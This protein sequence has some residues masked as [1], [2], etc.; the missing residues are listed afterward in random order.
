MTKRQNSSPAGSASPAADKSSTIDRRQFLTGTGATALSLAFLQPGSL[1]QGCGLSSFM[2][3][4]GCNKNY[5]ADYQAAGITVSGQ[6][7]YCEKLNV[8]AAFPTPPT[9]PHAIVHQSVTIYPDPTKLLSGEYDTKLAT[10]MAGAVAGDMLSCWQESAGMGYKDLNGNLITP[11][12]QNDMQLY[13]QSFAKAH[14]ADLVVGAVETPDWTKNQPWMAPGLD[15]YGIDMYQ[16][17]EPDPTTTLS[18]WEGHVL[19]YGS[20]HATVAVCECNASRKGLRPCYF[21][22]TAN[23]LANQKRKGPSC[24]LTYWNPTGKLSGPWLTNDPPTI[25]ELKNIGNGDYTNPGGC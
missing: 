16:R 4:R 23:W 17:D 1:L 3:M 18:E 11:T 6:R 5:V 22:E 25:D 7:Y 19:T 21:Y 14:H 24:F 2:L 9:D 13:L 12:Q 8:P 20:P 10:F 15:F